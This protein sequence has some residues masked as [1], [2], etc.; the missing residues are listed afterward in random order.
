[1]LSKYK[2]NELEDIK[3]RIEDHQ[4][5]LNQKKQELYEEKQRLFDLLGSNVPRTSSLQSLKSLKS[6]K[7]KSNQKYNTITTSLLKKD[8][9]SERQSSGDSFNSDDISEQFV[10]LNEVTKKGFNFDLKSAESFVS[11][12]GSPNKRSQ[13]SSTRSVFAKNKSIQFQNSLMGSLSNRPLV[14]PAK[15]TKKL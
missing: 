15:K 10:L 14:Q 13:L 11:P 5:Q 12:P 6:S 3:K 1:M 8:L 2:M 9:M 4:K 7:G